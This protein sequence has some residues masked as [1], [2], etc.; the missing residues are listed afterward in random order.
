MSH[1]GA[2]RAWRRVSPRRTTIAHLGPPLLALALAAAWIGLSPGGGRAATPSQLAVAG[3]VVLTGIAAGAVLGGLAVAAQRRIV[4]D[5][6]HDLRLPLTIIRGEVELVLS[7][8][9]V[10]ASERARSSQAV[11]AETERLERIL[12]EAG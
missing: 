3:L 1:G 9:E 7:R 10:W 5:L 2:P 8:P 4:E 11:I 12:H 6:D